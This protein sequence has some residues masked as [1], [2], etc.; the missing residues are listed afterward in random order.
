MR[1]QHL[2][3]R[4]NKEDRNAPIAV[5]CRAGVF[6]ASKRIDFLREMLGRHVGFFRQGKVG[7]RNKF[8]P[9]GVAGRQEKGGG[10]EGK[11]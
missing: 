7:E 6:L 8:L 9:R 4:N 11:K 5:A 1:E 3:S 10:G 2:N